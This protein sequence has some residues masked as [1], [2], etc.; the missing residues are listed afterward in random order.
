M[1][2]VA[3][4]AEGAVYAWG[5]DR[6]GQLGGGC[7]DKR[8]SPLPMKVGLPGPAVT[9]AAGGRH[10]A[11]VLEGGELMLWGWGE[12]G[13]LGNGAEANETVPREAALPSAAEVAGGRM[14]KVSGIALGT[15]HSAIIVENEN[16]VGIQ[17]EDEPTLA[18]SPEMVTAP[19]PPEPKPKLFSS[20]TPADIEAQAARD[21]ERAEAEAAAAERQASVLAARREKERETM[22]RFEGRKE[23]IKRREREE[24]VRRELARRAPSPVKA[25]SPAK[26][27]SP[28]PPAAAPSPIQVPEPADDD[29]GSSRENREELGNGALARLKREESARPQSPNTVSFKS[30]VN[31]DQIYYHPDQPVEKCFVANSARRAMLRQMAG[32][33]RNQGARAPNQGARAP[34]QGGRAPSQPQRS[35]G[36]QQQQQQQ[37]S[38]TLG[39]GVGG[40]GGDAGERPRSS[41]ILRRS[42]FNGAA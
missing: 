8:G 6:F 20:P 15:S 21:R 17:R 26:A 3:L 33:A 34:N 22:A 41:S 28:P 39:F 13:Q 30:K 37:L 27:L 18:A 9:I 7:L 5:D 16:V 24:D 25:A 14:G 42:S 40:G 38:R 36:K 32:A 12:E 10:T 4:T 2:S 29:S 35:P 31:Y 11:C 23:E 1:H 19:T